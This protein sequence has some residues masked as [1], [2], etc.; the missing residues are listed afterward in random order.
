MKFKNQENQLGC[1]YFPS[2]ETAEDP[3]FETMESF[4]SIPLTVYCENGDV[5]KGKKKKEKMAKRIVSRI[6]PTTEMI[7]SVHLQMFNSDGFVNQAMKTFSWNFCL[8]YI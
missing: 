6:R 8:I 4:C 3:N 5:V 7:D 2:K 1:A